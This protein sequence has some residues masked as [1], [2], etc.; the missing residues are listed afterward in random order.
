MTRAIARWLL[1]PT[2]LV[3]AA[4]TS[5]WGEIE[6][7]S[8][9]FELQLGYYQADPEILDDAVTLGFRAGKILG[10]R[11]G[12]FG[13]LAW[14]DGGE[15]GTIP[16]QLL[17]VGVD[18]E[19]LF[20]DFVGEYYFNPA[21]A[22]NFSAFAGAGWA[23]V[24]TRATASVRGAGIPIT[25]TLGGDS[26]EM[27]AGLALRFRV[28]EKFYLRPAYRIRWLEARRG[29]DLDREALLAFGFKF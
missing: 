21:G 7:D 11:L 2:L 26:F 27:Q 4:T 6:T 13:E 24:S 28:G 5:A 17:T 1:F 10:N 8:R 29:D 22:V 15:T 14:F 3:V 12:L 25:E 20:L 18:Y 16:E 9:E 19:V 23:F